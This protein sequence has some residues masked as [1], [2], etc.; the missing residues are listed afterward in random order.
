M[1]AKEKANELANKMYRGNVF[2]KT[3]DEHLIELEMAKRYAQIAVDE[4]INDNPNIYD[5]DRLNFKYWNEVKK[6]IAFL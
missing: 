5:S 3:K 2:E 6:Q 4:I 1:K